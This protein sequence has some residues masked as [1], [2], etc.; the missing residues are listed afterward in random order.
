MQI[1]LRNKTLLVTGSTQGLGLCIATMAVECGVSSLVVTGRNAKRGKAAAEKLSND[2]TKCWFIESDLSLPDAPQQLFSES[3][4]LAGDIDLLVNSAGLTNRASF[5]DGDFQTWETLFSVNARA[6]F[7]LMQQVIK[8]LLE[9]KSAGSIVNIQSMNA[10]CGTPELAIYAATKGALQTLTKNAANA[11]LSSG[12]RVNGINM[13]W[14]PTDAEMAMQAETLGNGAGW[15]EKV[16][17]QMPLKRMLRPEEVARVALFLLS[18]LSVPM[19]GVSL[20]VEQ[21]V[22]GSPK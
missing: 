8:S 4:G 2:K 11:F 18:D 14:A 5:M 21:T 7:F 15:I 1:D 16:S 6:P 9:R 12:I 13:G 3:I 22:V 10:H 20:D 17:R 19:T